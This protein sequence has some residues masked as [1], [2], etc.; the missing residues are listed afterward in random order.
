MILLSWERVYVKRIA[1]QLGE[2]ESL[3]GVERVERK[4]LELGYRFFKRYGEYLLRDGIF[5][6]SKGN[7]YKVRVL[8][9]TF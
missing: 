2:F 3:V 9:V 8:D 6:D 4:N 5:S 7:T 1:V